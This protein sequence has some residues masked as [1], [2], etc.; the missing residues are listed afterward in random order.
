[1][2][3]T[4]RIKRPIGRVA[5]GESSKLARRFVTKNPQNY[6]IPL[7]APGGSVT[8]LNRKAVRADVRGLQRKLGA[9]RTKAWVKAHKLQ[10][11]KSSMRHGFNP[12]A[13]SKKLGAKSKYQTKSGDVNQKK[14]DA[15]VQ[16]LRRKAAVSKA[17]LLK[18]KEP[19]KAKLVPPIQAKLVPPS[20][21]KT[22]G[23]GG[24]SGEH[25]KDRRNLRR[26]GALA[27]ANQ[28]YRKRIMSIPGSLHRAASYKFGQ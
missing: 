3:A 2:A 21:I 7:Y 28:F 17:K 4:P 24:L 25:E 22:G 5:R 26:L 14:V 8:V 19:I 11:Q 20:K 27:A 12:S 9:R 16:K 15:D 6:Q 18:S 10:S 13:V 1:M 23:G